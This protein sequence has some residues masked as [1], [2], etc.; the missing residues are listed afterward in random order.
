MKAYLDVNPLNSI[1]NTY[2]AA[3]DEEEPLQQVRKG[4]TIQDMEDALAAKTRAVEELNRELEEIRAAFGTE[5]VQQV[6]V[7]SLLV[8]WHLC[9]IK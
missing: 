7:L 5:G 4:D 9:F 2:F 3:Q 8:F 1:K 6:C